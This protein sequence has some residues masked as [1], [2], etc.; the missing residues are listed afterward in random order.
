MGAKY[1][2]LLSF[3]CPG[4]RR[5]VLGNKAKRIVFIEIHRSEFGLTNPHRVPQHALEYRLQLARRAADDLQNLRSRS[6]LLKRFGKLARA[7]LHLIEQAHVFDRDHRLVG[8]G[9]DKADL[10][11]GEWPHRLGLQDNDPDW[12]SFAQQWQPQ[13]RAS[14]ADFRSFLQGVFRIGQNIGDLDDASFLQDT[15]EDR[16]SPGWDWMLFHERLEFGRKTVKGNLPEGIAI[17][18]CDADHVR[19]TQARGGLDQRLEHNFEVERR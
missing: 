7:R 15:T 16:S 2:L 19:L 5:V 9:G 1:R 6:L 4:N 12:S 14:A 11:L 10:L 3:R 17:R 8:E 13:P 18:A